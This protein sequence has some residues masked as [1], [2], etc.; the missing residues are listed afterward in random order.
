MTEEIFPV[1][2][3]EVR[4]NPLTDSDCWSC[5]LIAALYHIA[6]D[7]TAFG[8]PMFEASYALDECVA[9]RTENERKEANLPSVS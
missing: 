7:A 3:L 4:H 6:T 2:P 5:G 9:W 8:D 1:C